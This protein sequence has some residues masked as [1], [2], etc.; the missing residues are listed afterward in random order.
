M[1]KKLADPGIGFVEKLR[2]AVNLELDYWEDRDNPP[3]LSKA[4]FKILIQQI[5]TSVSVSYASRDSFSGPHGKTGEDQVFKLRFSVAKM[6]KRKAYFL[7]GYFFDK[8]NC[9]GV[10]IQSFRE[11]VGLQI[12]K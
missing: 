5:P 6:G 8:G 4:V 12:L 2:L 9:K 11:E 10:C 7:K 1:L 3:N